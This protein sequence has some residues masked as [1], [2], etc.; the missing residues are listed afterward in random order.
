MEGSENLFFQNLDILFEASKR[1]GA[2][3]KSVLANPESDGLVIDQCLEF[4]EKLL[5]YASVTPLLRSDFFAMGILELD[6]QKIDVLVQQT[7]LSAEYAALRE[8]FPTPEN[9]AKF[10]T[11]Q[12]M[13][14]VHASLK[15]NMQRYQKNLRDRSLFGKCALDRTDEE[16]T[17]IA[18]ALAVDDEFLERFVMNTNPLNRLP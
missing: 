1:F 11:E 15:E 17:I 8:K 16:N 5:R 12:A 18:Q 6:I 14:I 4:F 2:T 3:W 7:P 9:P 13:I 10:S